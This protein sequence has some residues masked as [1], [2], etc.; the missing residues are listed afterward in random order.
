MDTRQEETEN[1]EQPAP[2]NEQTTGNPQRGAAPPSA[3][4]S[5]PPSTAEL[6]M[7]V[8]QR[9]RDEPPALFP[10]LVLPGCT[11]Q[12]AAHQQVQAHWP[13]AGHAGTVFIQKLIRQYLRW[14]INPIV[15]QQNIFNAALTTSITPLITADT[16]VRTMVA[17]LRVKRK[18]QHQQR[19]A[20]RENPDKTS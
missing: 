12:L 1:Q 14:L 8:E 16:D 6:Q 17:A 7:R 9:S 3:D 13:L 20:E 11:A 18:R 5:P 10:E 19:T 4:T 15:E 2:G